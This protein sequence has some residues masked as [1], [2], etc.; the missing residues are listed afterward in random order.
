[1][2]QNLIYII[3]YIFFKQPLYLANSLSSCCLLLI[4]TPWSFF[5]SFKMSCLFLSSYMVSFILPH[6]LCQSQFIVSWPSLMQY[7]NFFFILLNFI[8]LHLQIFYLL[9]VTWY[10]IPSWDFSVLHICTNLLDA[11]L[12]LTSFDNHV[13]KNSNFKI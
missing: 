5:I 4:M 1:M 3:F 13:R 10:S 9:D 8:I 7:F 11:L 2:L 6:L 12:N